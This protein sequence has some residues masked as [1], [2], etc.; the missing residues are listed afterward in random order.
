MIP[1]YGLKV[2]DV[3]M[4]FKNWSLYLEIFASYICISNDLDL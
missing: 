1:Y 3:E 2:S 4:V